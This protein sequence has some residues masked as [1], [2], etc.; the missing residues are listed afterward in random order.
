MDTG[1]FAS[2]VLSTFPKPT[3]PFTKPAGVVIVLFV[4]VCVPVVVTRIDVSAIPWIF[5]VSASW[6]VSA[7]AALLAVVEAVESTYTFVEA[8]VLLTGVGTVTV[9][10]KVGEAS[11]AFVSI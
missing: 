5:V 4:S 3:S 6:L 2:E 11:G 10:V 7:V 1:L 8:S 9:P